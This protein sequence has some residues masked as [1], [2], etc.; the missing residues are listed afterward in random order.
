MIESDTGAKRIAWIEA[1]HMCENKHDTPRI[2]DSNNK[3]SYGFV[4]FQRSTFDAYG[5]KYGLSH[6]DISSDEQQE[7]IAL[8]M[9]NEGKWRHWLNCGRKVTRDLGYTYPLDD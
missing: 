4:M 9:L 7:M 6:D 5:V 8:Y 2:L 1:L 3:Y